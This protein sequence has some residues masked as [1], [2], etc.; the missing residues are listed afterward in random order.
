MKTQT[1]AWEMVRDICKRFPVEVHLLDCCGG[2]GDEESCREFLKWMKERF[3]SFPKDID[4]IM[5]YYPT[6][7]GIIDVNFEDI[8]DQALS[9]WLRLTD[10]LGFFHDVVAAPNNGEGYPMKDMH[11][12]PAV[13]KSMYVEGLSIIVDRFEEENPLPTCN[14]ANNG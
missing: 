9:Q 4:S 1:E 12:I 8:D 10:V 5:A 7:E 14:G 13:L 2:S 3:P 11:D 6:L